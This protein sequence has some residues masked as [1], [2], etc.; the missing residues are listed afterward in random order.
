MS[1]LLETKLTQVFTIYCK[2]EDENKIPYFNLLKK[3]FRCKFSACQYAISKITQ[4]LNEI[5]IEYKDSEYR[6]LP[7][8][9]SVIYTLFN[10]KRVP[11]EKYEYFLQEHKKFF[12]GISYTPTMFFVSEHSIN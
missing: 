4:M 10:M 2:T 12:R 7:I 3:A 8:H 1:N 9:S 6:T 11:I 5:S